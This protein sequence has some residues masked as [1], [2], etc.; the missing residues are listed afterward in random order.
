MGIYTKT[1]DKGTTALYGGTRVAKDALQVE[2]YG[3]VDE[4]NALVSV[5]E[6]SLTDE[7]NKILL[8]QVQFALF[9]LGAELASADPQNYCEQ[10]RHIQEDDITALEQHIDVCMAAVPAMNQFVLPGRSEAGSRLHQART[11]ARRAERRLVQLNHDLELR[12]LVLKYVNRLSD[13]FY[14]VA[15][16]ED[17]QAL[18]AQIIAKVAEKYMTAVQSYNQEPSQSQSQLSHNRIRPETNDSTSISGSSFKGQD[19]MNFQQQ[20]EAASEISFGNIHQ[21]F[22]QAIDEAIRIELPVVIS[23]CDRHGNLIMTYRMPEALL[24]SI[25]LAFKKAYSAV[26]LKMSTDK[27][28]G[29]VQPGAPLYDLVASCDNKVVAFGGG[30]PIYDQSGKIIAAI[31]VSGGSVEQDMQVAQAGLS[32]LVF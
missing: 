5:A 11:V 12:P 32:G 25:D 13:F 9:Y 26:A 16:H 29:A 28:A 6:K 21:I 4:L 23:I 7:N 17:H 20:Q 3:T 2:A 1:G 31:G 27:I 14:A 8:E 10:H 30:F 15:R 19:V 18:Q 24:V 22:K